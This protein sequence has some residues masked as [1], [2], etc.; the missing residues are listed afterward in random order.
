MQSQ[1][2]LG[3][4]GSNQIKKTLPNKKPPKSKK[5]EKTIT[6]EV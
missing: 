1:V 5:E 3:Y 4:D 2:F 6:Y